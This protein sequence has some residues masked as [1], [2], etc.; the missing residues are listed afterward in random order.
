MS[1]FKG[2]KGKWEIRPTSVL[3][4]GGKPLFYDIVVNGSSFM[5]THKNEYIEGMS[6]IQQEANA[7]VISC[8]LEMLQMLK[9]IA[10][11]NVSKHYFKINK[12]IKKATT[13]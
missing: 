11:E 10:K 5:S 9:E 6:D 13:I 2:T 4:K 8:T 7:Q 3:N 12:L 1:E